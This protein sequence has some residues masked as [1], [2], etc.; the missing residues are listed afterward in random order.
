MMSRLRRYLLSTTS[1][2]SIAQAWGAQAQAER[3]QGASP[4]TAASAAPASVDHDADP[5]HHDNDGE[6]R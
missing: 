2:A 3:N 4:D 1:H 5:L 6:Q